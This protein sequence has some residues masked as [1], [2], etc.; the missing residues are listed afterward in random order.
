MPNSIQNNRS[1]YCLEKAP[2]F[3]NLVYDS[4][5]DAINAPSGEIDVQYDESGLAINVKFDPSI[6]EYDQAYDNSVPSETF[7]QYYDEISDY[8]NA[9]YSLE[10]GMIIDIGCGKGAFI[11]RMLRRIPEASAVGVDPSYEGSLSKLSGRLLFRQE[12]FSNKIEIGEASLVVCRHVL[13]HIPDPALFLKDIF[14]K[15][16]TQRQIPVFIEVPDLDWITE[17]NAFWDFC[18]EHVNYFTADTLAH[19]IQ[20][21]GGELKKISNAFGGQY[22]WAEVMV[23]SNGE[24]SMHTEIPERGLAEVDQERHVSDSVSTLVE[25]IRKIQSDHK[26]IIWGM[27]TKGIM[28]SLKLKQLGIDCDFFVDINENKQGKYCPITAYKISAPENIELGYKYA[29]ICMNPN[30]AKEIHNQC[31]NIGINAKL[32]D[33]MLNDILSLVQV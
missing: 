27:A 14:S 25:K 22:L 6:V 31:R 9:N 13:E 29:V 11:E 19:C 16:C 4:A 10:E 5:E 30:Y 8:L 28:Y 26:L 7:M 20:Q 2:V 33:P 32:Y 15:I 24:L 18:Y 23:S 12:Y 17:N 3:Q 1:I 21:A